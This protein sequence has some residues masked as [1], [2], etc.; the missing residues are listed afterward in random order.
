MYTPSHLTDFLGTETPKAWCESA[1]QNINIL[2][3][4]HAHCERK[5]ATSAIQLITKNPHAEDLIDKL[6][7]I[8]REEMLHFE[9]VRKILR[10]RK[11]KFQALPPSRYSRGLHALRS[12]TGNQESLRDDLIIGAIIEARSCERFFALIPY[13]KDFPEIQQF[14]THLADAEQRHFEI[15]WN[16]AKQIDKKV[17]WRLNEFLALENEM[18]KGP[19]ALFRFHS[20]TPTV[21][22]C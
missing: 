15:Y 1:I 21:G 3:I 10:K 9:K 2:L 22:G 19:D 7:P 14:Y 6:S 18:I 17:H 5:A 20:G 11:V 12:K 8:V 13:L 4:D 16:F